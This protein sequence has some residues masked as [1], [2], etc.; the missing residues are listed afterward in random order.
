MSDVMRD[1]WPQDVTTEDVLSP[2]DILRAQA[3]HL[4]RRMNRLLIG[5]LIKTEAEDRIVIGFEAEAPLAKCR[6][7]LFEIQHRPDL[8]YPVVI[9]PPDQELP[10]YLQREVYSGGLRDAVDRLS[11]PSKMVENEWVAGSPEEFSEK[12]ERVLAMA[13]VKAA[14]FSLLS[15]S[16]RNELTSDNEPPKS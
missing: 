13:E 11:A 5:H 3:D 10:R 7:R 16:K 9:V 12:L 15:R 2:E 6:A 4:T 1:M 14:I 8:D